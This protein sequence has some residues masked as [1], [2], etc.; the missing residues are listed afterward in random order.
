MISCPRIQ[1]PVDIRHQTRLY[2]AG[3]G[4]INLPTVAAIVASVDV[5]V[6]ATLGGAFPLF[7]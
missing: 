4:G 3:V 1:L 2:I 5:V 7:S 6:A